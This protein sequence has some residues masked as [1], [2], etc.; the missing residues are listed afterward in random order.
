[1]HIAVECDGLRFINGVCGAGDW[2]RRMGGGS[3]ERR[4]SSAAGDEQSSDEE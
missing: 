2:S 4:I 1:M 3:L